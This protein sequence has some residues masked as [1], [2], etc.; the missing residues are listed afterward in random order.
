MR[1]LHLRQA[2]ETTYSTPTAH[3]GNTLTTRIGLLFF[4]DKKII[5]EAM[6]STLIAMLHQ[7]HVSANK[8]DQSVETFWWPGM[9][10]E[11]R[12]KA[13]NCP[14]CR[15]ADKKLKAQIPHTEVNRLESLTEPIREV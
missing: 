15:A 4:N 5:P 9:H 1:K 12:E 7:R 10:R 2:N 8:M 14:S 13:A 3:T 11:I 6:R